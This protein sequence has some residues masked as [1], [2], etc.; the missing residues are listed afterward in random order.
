MLLLN[1]FF[2]WIF[3]ELKQ[4]SYRNL[5]W[6]REQMPHDLYRHTDTLLLSTK[7]K[8]KKEKIHRN[9]ASQDKSKGHWKR[10]FR[11]RRITFPENSTI[12]QLSVLRMDPRT[13]CDIHCSDGEWKCGTH[14]AGARAATI[15]MPRQTSNHSF[16]HISLHSAR[17][18]FSHS[19]KW[20]ACFL[21]ASL[22]L[23]CKYSASPFGVFGR[24]REKLTRTLAIHRQHTNKLN[25]ENSRRRR[26]FF[27]SFFYSL[28]VVDLTERIA[29]EQNRREK[30]I[31]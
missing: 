28:M 31:I 22:R 18:S 8:K 5:K 26:R 14:V 7:E 27:L 10:K 20:N 6:H 16:C 29:L 25:V 12:L 30:V 1:L 15:P 3:H 4:Q 9:S 19:V 23:H 17:Q 11:M 2:G 21:L 13:P 24:I